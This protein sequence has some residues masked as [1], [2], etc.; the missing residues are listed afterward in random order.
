MTVLLF[1]ELSIWSYDGRVFSLC[2]YLVVPVLD[3]CSILWLVCPLRILGKCGEYG[4]LVGECFCLTEVEFPGNVDGVAGG[5]PTSSCCRTR[6]SE[7]ETVRIVKIAYL[8]PNWVWP[9][10][11]SGI[12]CFCESIQ[13]QYSSIQT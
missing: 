9:L 1:W 4:F 5:A 7:G 12:Q 6:R 8:C 2:R 3:G 11:V 10:E 13:N